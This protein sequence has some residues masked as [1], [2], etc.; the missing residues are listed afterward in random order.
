MLVG[1]T[2]PITQNSPSSLPGHMTI[3]V[4][5]WFRAGHLGVEKGLHVQ[6][7]VLGSNDF[8]LTVALF[9]VQPLVVNRNP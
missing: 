4:L 5:I 9:G 6:V 8:L 2:G 7:S 3:E 1:V